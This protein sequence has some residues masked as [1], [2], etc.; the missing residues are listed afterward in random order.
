MDYSCDWRF[1][2][3]D[4]YV[5]IN[6]QLRRKKVSRLIYSL[7]EAISDD[8]TRFGVPMKGKFFRGTHRFQ[9]FKVGDTFTEYGFMSKSTDRSVAKQFSV[10]L[11][12]VIRYRKPV[13]HLSLGSFMN[14]PFFAD[15]S[16][17]Q[18]FITYP[19]EQF[20]VTKVKDGVVYMERTGNAFDNTSIK[21]LVD[22]S[23]D[24]KAFA[25]ANRLINKPFD[26]IS[27]M[28][29]NIKMTRLRFFR[30][31]LAVKAVKEGKF[32]MVC[33]AESRLYAGA[34]YEMLLFSH[35]RKLEGA[36]QEDFGPNFIA[37]AA[38]YSHELGEFLRARVID[39]VI[40]PVIRN[41]IQYIRTKKTKEVEW[42][43]DY[44]AFKNIKEGETVYDLGFIPKRIGAGSVKIEYNNP[45]DALPLTDIT[46][47][48]LFMMVP[49]ET[50]Y[51][52]YKDSHRAHLVH[53][54]YRKPQR[55]DDKVHKRFLGFLE[56]GRGP[57]T[58]E[59]F[60]LITLFRAIQDYPQYFAIFS[61]A[62]VK[63]L[64]L[65]YAAFLQGKDILDEKLEKL[66]EIGR[67]IEI[68]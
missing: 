52:L 15:F 42:S 4:F 55:P 62:H 11:L 9:E 60:I 49:G 20:T 21:D 29:A 67:E 63:A 35:P 44:K 22:E 18:E 61:E 59:A 5:P 26:E 10:G 64:I 27:F 40:Y 14:W 46:G 51:V 1:Y 2:T 3:Q 23:L 48:D 33:T 39:A 8:V 65:I 17:Q 36:S 19:G 16:W 43:L 66:K 54:G 31:L 56:A 53:T 45:P 30:T 38:I 47:E 24:K 41:F 25:M 58:K 13:Q 32:F 7:I 28:G 12:F 50:F 37:T 68:N 57:M 6:E 34:A